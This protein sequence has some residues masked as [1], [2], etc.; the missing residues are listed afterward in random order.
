MASI[1]TSHDREYLIGPRLSD[2]NDS[3]G[4]TDEKRKRN[5]GEHGRFLPGND[6]GKGRGPKRAIVGA[7]QDLIERTAGGSLESS[8]AS[9]VA[10]GALK[11]YDAT[12]AN[13]GHDDPR[14]LAPALRFAVNV[15]LAGVFTKRAGEVGFTTEP[16]M[17]FLELAHKCEQRADRS[18]VQATAMAARL[19]DKTDPYV[20]TIQAGQAEFQRQLREKNGGSQ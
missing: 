19:V 11:L 14:V 9:E 13:L 16:G 18:S 3:S 10:E 5:H 2:I 4:G 20:E 6:A 17:V 7:V 8:E 12:R 15:M 1:E